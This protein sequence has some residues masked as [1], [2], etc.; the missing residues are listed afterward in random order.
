MTNADAAAAQRA[1]LEL[2]DQERY[3]EAEAALAGLPESPFVLWKRGA[4]RHGLNHFAE[5]MADLERAHA[6]LGDPLDRARCGLDIASA[7]IKWTRL[8]EAEAALAACRPALEAAGAEV[9]LARW[10]I[11]D[12]ARRQRAGDYAGFASGYGPVLERLTQ[13]GDSRWA[14]YALGQA[15]LGYRMRNEYAACEAAALRGLALAEP[16][17]LVYRQAHLR[18]SLATCANDRN[19]W[20][21]MKAWLDGARAGVAVSGG[22]LLEADIA[23]LDGS[24]Q[25]WQG[26]LVESI[27]CQ[28]RAFEM[29]RERGYT[30]G[31]GLAQRNIGWACFAQGDLQAAGAAHRAAERFGR[32]AGDPG[33]IGEALLG[34]GAVQTVL[35]NTKAAERLFLAAY[36]VAE[37]AGIRTF[38]AMAL[39]YAAAVCPSEAFDDLARRA[40]EQFG[41]T[42]PSNSLA[43]AIR[44]LGEHMLRYGRIDDARPLLIRAEA[45]EREFPHQW[46]MA[47][48]RL[49]ECELARLERGDADVDPAALRDLLGRAEA[50]SADLPD[51]RARVALAFAALD[52]RDG[53]PTAALARIADAVAALR[54][55]RAS[56]DDPVL[57]SVGARPLEQ[58]YFKGS[59]LA[60]ALGDAETA[61][62]FAEHRR[63]QWLTRGLNAHA[64]QPPARGELDEL[65]QLLRRR[66]AM[67]ERLRAGSG[68]VDPEGLAALRRAADEATRR[69][70]DFDARAM[71]DGARP[72]AL[73]E[74]LP[75][76]GPA[77]LRE[78]FTARLGSRWAAV[79]IEPLDEHAADWLI[80]RLTPDGLEGRRAPAGP[81]ERVMLRSLA[82][83]DAAFRRR[84]YGRA[85]G[86]HVALMALARWLGVADW[87]AADT[88]CPLI[89]A[90]T[91]PL[92]RITFA[93]L[94]LPDGSPLGVRTALRFAPSLNAAAQTAW[95]K[96]TKTIRALAVAPLEFGPRHEGLPGSASEAQAV[97][98]RWPGSTVLVGREASLAALREMADRGEL[99]GFDVIHFATHALTEP[100]QIRLSGLALADGDLTLQEIVSWRLSARLVSVSACESAFHVS[101]AGEERIGIET[102]LLSAGAGSILSARWPVADDASAA[103]MKAFY[104]R[105][106]ETGDAA[107]ALAAARTDLDG[108]VAAADLLAWRV[109]GLG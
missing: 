50:A 76:A 105:Y 92:T 24:Y 10:A 43:A 21:A 51:I 84:F 52:R 20:R 104:A 95:V 17:G 45:M 42:E 7:Y 109:L 53:A 65:A 5:A 106:A 101:Y 96:R 44:V 9:E 11:L 85:P 62:S 108:D 22:Q 74:A 66:R 30:A 34:Q 93:A 48:A 61:L 32:Q 29:Y 71:F 40:I 39:A 100:G 47:A 26:D 1:A 59:A 23:M 56:G 13:L 72:G 14:A 46:S 81:T 6:S 86:D 58:V 83:G 31:L 16:L 91:G 75:L 87:P 73:R 107:E 63:A 18:Y 38:M 77:A 57:A 35:G 2:L 90:D 19:D 97:A 99:A 68:E 69:Y 55:I 67:A 37:R 41:R 78:A 54:V 79:V 15:A 94:P 60:A 4:A 8:P 98:E 28:Q 3:R 103:V 82:D 36:A 70:A 25:Y 80:L 27:R 33:V 89:I 102:A 64:G 49:A 12:L 88:R